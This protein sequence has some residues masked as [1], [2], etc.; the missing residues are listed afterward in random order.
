[1]KK[2][3]L[4]IKEDL[5]DIDKVNSFFLDKTEVLKVSESGK[6]NFDIIVDY[7]KSNYKRRDNR[8]NLYGLLTKEPNIKDWQLRY[9]GQ[10]KAKDIRQRLRAH[11]FKR[12]NRTGAK[13]ASVNNA[14][15]NGLEIGIKLM[16]INPEELRSYYEA[17]LLNLQELNLDWNIHK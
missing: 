13:L 9:V 15:E 10:T 4:Q 11:L 16:I 7:F 6:I 1:M 12:N 17:K 5:L 2:V 3:K 8:P 14:L